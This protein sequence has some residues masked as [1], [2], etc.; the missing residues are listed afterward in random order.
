VIDVTEAAAEVGAADFVV[1]NRVVCCYPDMPRLTGLA[2]DHARELLVLSFP[3][4][5]WWTRAM[6][7]MG[8]AVLG[9]ARRGFH[10]FIHPPGGI[11][12]TA[13]EHGLTTI[14][15]SRGFFWQVAA[16]ERSA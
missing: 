6:L 16:L 8:N 14:H 10:V 3:R 11:L 4:R 15:N 5:S 9:A 12:A 13:G 1:M 2:A 7:G